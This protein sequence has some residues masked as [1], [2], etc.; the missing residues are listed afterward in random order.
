MNHFQP[1][2]ARNV[3]ERVKAG[4]SVLCVSSVSSISI[5]SINLLWSFFRIKA[6]YSLYCGT[7]HDRWNDCH[8]WKVWDHFGR[9]PYFT[10]AYHHITLYMAGDNSNL[11]VNY[12]FEQDRWDRLRGPSSQ[13]GAFLQEDSICEVNER[14][15]NVHNRNWPWLLFFSQPCILTV[16]LTDFWLWVLCST[17]R[18][19]MGRYKEYFSSHP[20]RYC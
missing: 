12:I 11:V 19:F 9:L 17:Q 7:I 5:L 20:T 14:V 16:C 15:F 1:F 2:F 18:I 8:H 13:D 10:K 4:I 3:M 6:L